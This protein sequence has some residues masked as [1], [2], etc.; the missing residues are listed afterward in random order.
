MNN[1]QLSLSYLERMVN[2][3]MSQAHKEGLSHL[4]AKQD[5]QKRC[6]VS[7]LPEIGR[8]EG[9]ERYCLKG[10]TPAHAHMPTRTHAKMHTCKNAHAH[11]NHS[12]QGKKKGRTEIG[13]GLKRLNKLG[14]SASMAKRKSVTSA[15]SQ[16]QDALQLVWNSSPLNSPFPQPWT[17]V[18]FLVAFP[19]VSGSNK[20]N[21]K[22]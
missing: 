15:S 22:L 17:S 9:R 20:F 10:H 14:R 8:G 1:V 4:K 12:G 19:G 11:A 18:R 5:S 2:R 6:L 21:C 16:Q 13:C 3:S 7:L